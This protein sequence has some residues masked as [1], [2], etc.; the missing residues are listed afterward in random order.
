MAV[1]TLLAAAVAATA[2]AEAVSEA[3]SEDWTG[4]IRGL[5]GR[6]IRNGPKDL[7]RRNH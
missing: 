4:T 6:A 5:A 2:E 7:Q 3:L 1:E